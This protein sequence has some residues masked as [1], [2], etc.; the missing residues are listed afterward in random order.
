M[1]EED[2]IEQAMRVGLRSAEMLEWGLDYARRN[3]G[4]KGS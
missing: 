4:G 1:E 3:P 2:A